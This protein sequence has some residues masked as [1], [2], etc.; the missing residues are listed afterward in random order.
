MKRL[1]WMSLE[2]KQSGLQKA[3]DARDRFLVHHGVN[4]LQVH[5]PDI[6]IHRLAWVYQIEEFL[7]EACG[8]EPDSQQ[9]DEAVKFI[10]PRLNHH[11]CSTVRH[12]HEC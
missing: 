7:Y 1:K 9:V 3:I 6:T 10:D 8:L 11:S 12:R 4:T 5:Y 2:E